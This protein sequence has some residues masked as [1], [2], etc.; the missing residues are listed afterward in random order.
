MDKLNKIFV[1]ALGLVLMASCSV[2]TVEIPFDETV[3]A[4]FSEIVR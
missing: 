3:K 4:D 1:A 2:K